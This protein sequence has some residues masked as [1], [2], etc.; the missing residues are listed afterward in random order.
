M[1][2]SL[3]VGDIIRARVWS[4]FSGAG[5]G[6]AV[7]TLHYVVAAVGGVPATDRDVA[8]FID[9]VV[10]A[11]YKDLM[12]DTADY[13]GIQAQILVSTPPYRA[14]FGEQFEAG[15]Q[16]PGTA[17]STP[18]PAQICGLISFGTDL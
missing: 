2:V 13:R 5:G 12:T 4:A 18:L 1:A 16:G 6:A 14:K 3:S 8:T 7:N 17:G 11:Q 9:S 10:A 15:S